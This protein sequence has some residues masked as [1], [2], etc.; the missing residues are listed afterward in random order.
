MRILIVT[1]YFWPETFR[2]NDV[3]Q[4]LR[5][6]GHE[7]SVLTGKPNYPSGRFFPG[8]GF[9]G[10]SRE[11]YAGAQ[12]I[13]VPLLP[14]GGGGGLRLLLNYLSFALLASVLAPW[15]CRGPLDVILVYEP[16]PVTV[17]LPALALKAVKRAPIL[18]WVQDLW[19]ESLSATGAVRTRWVLRAVATLVRFIYRGCDRILVQSRAFI[20]PV[21]AMG[22][23]DERILYLPN[24]A[25]ALYRPAARDA[26][27]PERPLPEGFR[28]MFAGNIGAAQSFDTILAAA[29]ALRDRPDIHW[30]VLGEG[31]LQ[32][33]VRQ[34]IERR[35]LSDCV[36]LLGRFPVESMPAWFAQADAML[37][38]LKRDP[39][40]ALTIPSKVQ[41]YM[42]CARPIVAALDGEGARVIE[43]AR[44]GIVVAPEDAAALACAVLDMVKMPRAEREAMGERG[45]AY[46]VREFERDM[47]LARVEAWMRELTARE[48]ACVP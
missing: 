38:T 30:L 19:P 46:F 25:E 29:Q 6:L 42:A 48:A 16:S 13:R 31:R 10:R 32:R 44:A 28:I 9:F 14:R 34:E 20:G 39:I 3:V 5:A 37:V 1:Q 33:W 23:P 24:S 4:G 7:V 27:P 36:H 35:G 17:G 8:Y 22:V 2:I 11:S 40:F 41:S 47:L 45:R 18:F 12:V 15:R 26:T 43:E 21:R